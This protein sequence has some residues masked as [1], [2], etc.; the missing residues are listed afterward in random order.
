MSGDVL[1]DIGHLGLGSRVKRLAERLLS[2]AAVIHAESGEPL[3]PGQ[4]PVIAA[5]DRYGP[6]TV[7]AAV[8]AVGISQPAMTRAIS[9]LVASG[10]VVV[11]PSRDD[12]RQKLISLSEA[13]QALVARMKRAMWPRVDAAARD[14][15]TG[16]SGDF[17]AQLSQVE[18]R[19][20]EQ[21]LLARVRADAR[22]IVP[23]RDDLAPLFYTINAEWIEDMFVLEDHDRH[24]LSNPRETIIDRGG[25]VLFVAVGGLG[26][27]GTCALQPDDHGFIEL[28]KMG[29]LKVARDAKVGE[30][31]LRAVLEVAR[32]RGFLE[33][34]YL[35]TNTACA[36]AIHLYE[37]LGFVHDGEIM[38]LFGSR[39]A[40]CDVAMRYRG[41]GQA[42]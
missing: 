38:N 12:K 29:V 26:I 21:S 36:P 3:Q 10:L 39:Y 7:N 37:K 22:E 19:L 17:L 11:T 4:F 6:L 5:L 15:F 34:L 8:A 33:K 18:A 30:F 9:D 41:P 16:L 23:Y 28:T 13:G 24:V 2:D 35:V 32:A 20:S 25:D 42:V 40:R 27:V 31:L 14:L 1:A